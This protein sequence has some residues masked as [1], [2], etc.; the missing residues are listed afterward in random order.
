MNWNTHSIFISS[1]KLKEKN[2]NL[3]VGSVLHA[4]NRE[5]L[6]STPLETKAFKRTSV[7]GCNLKY[8]DHHILI[9]PYIQIENLA[10]KL[11]MAILDCSAACS[12]LYSKITTVYM[13]VL[14]LALSIWDFL[15][16][17]THYTQASTCWQK[18]KNWNWL[19]TKEFIFCGLIY[20]YM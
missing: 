19:K 9:L 15:I 3:H 16:N 10:S 7:L 13:Y 17:E 14:R 5:S 18:N 4:F 2:S 8:K 11:P 1:K 12:T 20:M 6:L